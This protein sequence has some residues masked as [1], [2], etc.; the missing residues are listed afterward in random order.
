MQLT[1]Y[2]RSPNEYAYYIDSCVALWLDSRAYNKQPPLRKACNFVFITPEL[3]SEFDTF[4]EKVTT[5][6]YS[7]FP[8]VAVLEFWKRNVR[9]S[10]G[11]ITVMHDKQY[12]HL[13]VSDVD[14]LCQWVYD[15][16]EACRKGRKIG[17][18]QDLHPSTLEGMGA[19]TLPPVSERQPASV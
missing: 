6:A 9:P 18:C 16:R 19:S 13:H 14:N 1:A 11:T 3:Q 2:E 8:L 17:D 5:P 15:T 10:A 4:R 12:M 7:L